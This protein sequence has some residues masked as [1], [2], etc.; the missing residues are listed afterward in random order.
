MHT[1]QHMSTCLLPLLYHLPAYQHM[2]ICMLLIRAYLPRAQFR[3]SST[4]TIF[5][6]FK[7]VSARAQPAAAPPP[8]PRSQHLTR[9]VLCAAIGGL[10]E[11]E[12]PQPPGANT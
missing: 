11:P 6:T 5:Y 1:S 12:A 10:G 8:I 3:S 7:K 9:V 4:S 2:S